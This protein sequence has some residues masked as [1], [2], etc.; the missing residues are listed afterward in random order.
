MLVLLYGYSGLV[1]SQLDA[2]WLALFTQNIGAKS[3][4]HDDQRADKEI[5]VIL[6]HVRSREYDDTT[7]I[8]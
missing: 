4:D 6:L 3:D 1:D 5:E 2:T 7:G 8:G